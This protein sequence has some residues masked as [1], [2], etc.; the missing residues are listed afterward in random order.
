MSWAQKTL[1]LK[2]RRRGFHLITD[3]VL[4]GVPEIRGYRVGLAHFFISLVVTLHGES[5]S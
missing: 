5:S 2:P 3:E 4:A 1:R